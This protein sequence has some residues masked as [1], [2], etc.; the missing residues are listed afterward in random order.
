[1]F[2][3]SEKNELW[4]MDDPSRIVQKNKKNYSFIKQIIKKQKQFKIV[5]TNLKNYR[6]LTE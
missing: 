5:R 6:F 3:S 1:M 2:V 4:M